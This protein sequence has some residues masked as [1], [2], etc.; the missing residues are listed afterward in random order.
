MI[1]ADLPQTAPH[2]FYRRLN[3]LLDEHGF[4]EFAEQRCEKFYAAR[5]SAR[6]PKDLGIAGMS[7]SALV[8]YV[9]CGGAS[10]SAR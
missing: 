9:E 7:K 10:G 2:P 4:D 3:E 1:L 8:D 5:K 6:T